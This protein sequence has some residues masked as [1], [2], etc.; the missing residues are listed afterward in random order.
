MATSWPNC[1]AA[2]LRTPSAAVHHDGNRTHQVAVEEASTHDD[3]PGM[4]VV[5]R[6]STV[7]VVVPTRTHQVC[8]GAVP[9]DRHG[10]HRIRTVQAVE[11]VHRGCRG[12]ATTR[13][14]LRSR[15]TPEADVK[16]NNDVHVPGPKRQTVSMTTVGD[17]HHHPYQ[18]QDGGVVSWQYWLLLQLEME[19]C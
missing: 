17:H 14:G 15:T 8:P 11:V 18:V 9:E 2:D 5:G 19:P 1:V 3:R 16:G 10:T 7:L 13:R 6:K 12:V 4:V